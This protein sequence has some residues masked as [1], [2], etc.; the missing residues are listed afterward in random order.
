M[1]KFSSS[2]TAG[3]LLVAGVAFAVYPALRPYGP[4]TGAVGAADF[5]STAWVVSHAC[6]MIGFVLVAV[7]LRFAAANPPWAWSG[8]AVR[9]VETRAWLA[10]ALLLPYYG[11][12]TYGLQ[13]IGQYAVEQGDPG[14]LAI[15][16]DFRLAP[17]AATTF[18]IGLLLL[19]WVG[20]GIARG[21]WSAGTLARA[22]G[23]LAGLG[24]AAYLPQFFGPP[25]LRV[26]H[27]IVLGMGLLLMG[28]S[29]LRP[30]VEQAVSSAPAGSVL[31]PGR[32]HE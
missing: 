4:E 25:G 3:A 12:E 31:T 10:V 13:A 18:L 28:V 27:G 22:G 14:V 30:R 7:A 17:F 32:A 2:R 5:A 23:V 11:A 20:W 16:E 24:L 9:A 19:V 21:L 29:V 15:A 8:P 1:W 6:G 26:A